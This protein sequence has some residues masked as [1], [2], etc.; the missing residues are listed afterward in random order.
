MIVP[1]K[2]KKKEVFLGFPHISSAPPVPLCTLCNVKIRRTYRTLWLPQLLLMYEPTDR[3]PIADISSD[4]LIACAQEAARMYLSDRFSRF[5]SD[6]QIYWRDTEL[7][8]DTDTDNLH[9]S[10]NVSFWVGEWPSTAVIT[11]DNIVFCGKH[12]I[13]QYA[14]GAYR[15]GVR[16]KCEVIQPSPTRFPNASPA[17]LRQLAVNHYSFFLDKTTRGGE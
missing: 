12:C 3:I 16:S 1:F 15:L 6:D 11:E 17:R 7:A 9:S 10:G 4:G 5:G 8:V 14:L 2:P 13:R